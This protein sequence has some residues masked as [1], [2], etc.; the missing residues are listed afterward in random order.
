MNKIFKLILTAIFV[1]GCLKMAISQPYSVRKANKL[2]SQYDYA[3]AII[4][5]K[6]SAQADSN[7][8]FQH[9]GEKM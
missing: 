3:Q 5:Y 8:L 1:F 6:K 7:N 4:Y 2:Y 9:T